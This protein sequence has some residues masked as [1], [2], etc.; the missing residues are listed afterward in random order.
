MKTILIIGGAGIALVALA[1]AV[2][3]L[4]LR[5][6]ARMTDQE[7]FAAARQRAI[8]YRLAAAKARAAKNTG[9]E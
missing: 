7:Y 4:R 8:S 1:P 2:R 6:A 9:D 3:A 5:K